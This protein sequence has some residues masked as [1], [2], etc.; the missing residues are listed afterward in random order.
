MQ[1]K[2]CPTQNRDAES[3]QKYLQG[4][5]ETGTR[6]V[7]RIPLRVRRLGMA[8]DA[9]HG[10]ERAAQRALD[11]VDVL[12]NLDHAHRRRGAAMEVDDFAGVGIAHPH[13]M[14]VVDRGTGSEAR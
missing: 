12:V 9:L 3:P 2:S 11:L 13:A 14:D 8:D 6:A 5:S 1:N 4:E 10:R 7:V